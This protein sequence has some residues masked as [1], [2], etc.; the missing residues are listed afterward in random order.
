MQRKNKIIFYS[1]TTIAIMT[2]I[3]IFSAQNADDSTRLSE[4]FISTLLGRIFEAIL[5]QF[6]LDYKFVI[7]K[8]AHVFEYLCLGVSVFMLL[9]E[10]RP[11]KYLFPA[12]GTE[13]T[14]FLY[15]CTDEW[16]QTFVPGRSGKLLDAFVDSIGFSIAIIFL[17]IAL[18]IYNLR[19]KV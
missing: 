16:H 15:A 13:I 12:L 9:H 18:Y 19:K 10:I 17:L 11:E 6:G 14:C 5:P 8:Y 7:R 3:F 4:G 2:V 1:L